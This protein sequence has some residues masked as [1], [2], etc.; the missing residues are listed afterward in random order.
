M[1]SLNE[2]NYGFKEITIICYNG[3]SKKVLISDTRRM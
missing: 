1:I 3:R 2:D